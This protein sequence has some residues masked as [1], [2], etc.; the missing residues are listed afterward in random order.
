[1]KIVFNFYLSHNVFK[2]RL[3]RSKILQKMFSVGLDVWYAVKWKVNG[4]YFVLTGKSVCKI[5]KTVY[6]KFFRKPFSKITHA[7]PRVLDHFHSSHSQSLLSLSLNCLLSFSLSQAT[8][9][10]ASSLLSFSLSARFLSHPNRAQPA[11]APIAEDHW[12]HRRFVAP[13][14]FSDGKPPTLRSLSLTDRIGSDQ[15]RSD[16]FF[17]SVPASSKAPRS[18]PIRSL[19]LFKASVN[20][21]IIVGKRS[22]NQSW[23]DELNKHR[24]K[25]MILF[26]FHF[27]FI[28]CLIFGNCW[29]FFVLAE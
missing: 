27:I 12:S 14:F 3:N 24:T 19:L 11:R 25:L 15:I 29:F 7:S 2:L 10:H 17:G 9:S 21:V 16:L 22:W 18:D 4:K 20:V 26:Y 28:F 23:S 1:M 5:R 13:I 8:P 6:G